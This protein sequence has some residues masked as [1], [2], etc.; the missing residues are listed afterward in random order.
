MNN[1]WD[2]G[3]LTN[4]ILAQIHN[5][6]ADISAYLNK[7]KPSYIDTEMTGFGTAKFE[8]E[9]VIEQETKENNDLIT[10]APKMY[11]LLK[12]IFELWD[13]GMII[14]NTETIESAKDL[15]AQIDGEEA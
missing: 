8:F 3:V 11:E 1:I 2:N 9:K 7:D 4:L 13:T 12:N 14:D 6:L 5:R 10:A 15:L